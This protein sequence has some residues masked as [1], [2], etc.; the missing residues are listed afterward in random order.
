[1]LITLCLGLSGCHEESRIT[2]LLNNPSQFQDVLQQCDESRTV[3]LGKGLSCDLI[4]SV[5]EKLESLQEESQTDPEAFGQRILDTEML[6]GKFQMSI[7][8]A[9]AVLLS[10]KQSHPSSPDVANLENKL[11]QAKAAYKQEKFELKLLFVIAKLS[12]PE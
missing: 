10:L 4:F 9:Q 11:A 6:L 2:T 12:S 3:D 1:M 7:Q 5:Q 8:E